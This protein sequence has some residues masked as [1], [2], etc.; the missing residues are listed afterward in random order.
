MI[1]MVAGGG[2]LLVLGFWGWQ[3]F[4]QPEASPSA[5]GIPA[6]VSSSESS[7]A[8]EEPPAA[9]ATEEHPPAAPLTIGVSWQDTLAALQSRTGEVAG[10]QGEERMKE[11]QTFAE[12]VSLAELPAALK[13]LQELQT[14]NPTATGRDLQMR[15]VRQWG[16]KDVD[17]AAAWVVTMPAG[18]D[19]QE[20]LSAVGGI[21][22][23]KSFDEAAAWAEKLP[24][25]GERNKVLES[26]A[27]EA[28][29]SEPID[30]LNLV[31]ALPSSESRNE[32]VLNASA[33]WAATA[34]REALAWAEKVPDKGLREQVTSSIA[35]KWGETDP[36]AAGQL[37]SKSLPA[38]PLQDR[39]V[40]AIVERWAFTNEAAAKAWVEKFPE[41]ELRKKALETVEY[42]GKRSRKEVLY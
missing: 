33:T 25:G 39:T 40:I 11:L 37:A 18:D 42:T 41:G 13:M 16:D 27:Y 31:S 24:A 28:V 10:Q 14:K 35:M 6:T 2:L 38:G 32:I 29:Y 17:G 15:L 34:P 21:W 26:V 8:S 20:A 1:S 7:A 12:S 22:A 30:A 9:L 23:R 4:G 3:Q 19:R 36:V 5:P